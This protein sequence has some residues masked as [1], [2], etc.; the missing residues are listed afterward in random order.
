MWRWPELLDLTFPGVF[1]GYLG[2]CAH[3]RCGSGTP[4]VSIVWVL[5][6]WCMGIALAG[7]VHELLVSVCV[8]VAFGLWRICQFTLEDLL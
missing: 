8:C 7:L 6:L 1:A 2:L 5:Q 3:P 4:P